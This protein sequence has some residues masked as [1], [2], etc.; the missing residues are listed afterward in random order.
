MGDARRRRRAQI[1]PRPDRGDDRGDGS[2]QQRHDRTQEEDRAHR[3]TAVAVEQ[4][5]I[6]GRENVPDDGNCFADDEAGEECE[7]NLEAAL[8]AFF[9]FIGE[10]ARAD[11]EYGPPEI[12]RELSGATSRYGALRFTLRCDYIS[13]P[14]H[15]LIGISV[16]AFAPNYFAIA[17]KNHPESI[18]QRIA[19][20]H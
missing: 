1:L 11:R 18:F 6:V 7:E 14:T 12:F 15:S 4:A 17:R 9:P 20:W 10:G 2:D 8:H 5:K 3:S 16:D 13:H 19:L